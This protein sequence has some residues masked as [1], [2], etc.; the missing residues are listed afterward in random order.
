MGAIVHC[1]IAVHGVTSLAALGLPATVADADVAQQA[2]FEVV[3]GMEEA[4]AASV[5]R[6][7][8]PQPGPI[9]TQSSWAC[10][11]RR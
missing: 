5:T 4:E 11:P 9:E 1:G 2:A 3:F 7:S 6:A 8:A 10:L